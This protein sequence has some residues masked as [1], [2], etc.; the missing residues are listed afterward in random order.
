MPKMHRWCQELYPPNRLWTNISKQMFK[1]C[2]WWCRHLV[3]DACTRHRPF[4]RS[5]SRTNCHKQQSYNIFLLNDASLF[6]TCSTSAT[7]FRRALHCYTVRPEVNIGWSQQSRTRWIPKCC[8]DHLVLWRTKRGARTT[9]FLYG[10][11]DITWGDPHR[12]TLYG[13]TRPC[14]AVQRHFRRERTRPS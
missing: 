12:R 6:C 9:K 10:N 13:A 1:C 11:F 3:E 8:E 5:E 7:L 14:T 4:F 2:V